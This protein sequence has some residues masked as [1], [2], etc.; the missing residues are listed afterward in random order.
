MW[1]AES[2]TFLCHRILGQPGEWYRRRWR[3]CNQANPRN[4]KVGGCGRMLFG[5][6]SKRATGLDKSVSALD[7][8]DASTGGVKAVKDTTKQSDQR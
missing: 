5:P 4:K 1:D 7:K 3:R 8:S 6:E 2:P